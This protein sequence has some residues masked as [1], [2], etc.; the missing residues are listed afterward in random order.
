MVLR[1]KLLKLKRII[2]RCSSCLIAFSG[3]VDSV[4]L[5]KVASQVLP[6]DKILAVTASSAIYPKEE[7]QFSKR[8]AK[9]FGIR[10][11]IITT[12]ELKNKKFTANPANRCYYC[13]EMLFLRLRDLAK[14]T[15]SNFVLD[16]SN[17]SDKSDF[18]PG[19]KAKMELNVRSPL[20]EAG[21]SKEEIRNLSKKLKLDTWD[22]P[23]LAC[24]ASRIPYG[25]KI[26]PA[27]LRRINKAELYLRGLGVKQVRLR[28]HGKLC[29]IET[30]KKGLP[31]LISKR[32]LII[33]K[34][35]KLGYN[36]VTL[37]L[38]GYRTGSLNE[39][40]KT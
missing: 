30:D 1:Q 22:K 18:R 34:L 25:I 26:T 10:H 16:A 29:R 19:T 32:K 2:K 31:V 28:H 4:F 23:A 27:V 36:Y 33:D 21:L 24:L 12:G 35:N 40:I 11:K 8:M 6:K 14:E 3:G 39:V 38:E 37:D 15:N 5:L 13:K 7:L 17:L 20:Q 9:Y